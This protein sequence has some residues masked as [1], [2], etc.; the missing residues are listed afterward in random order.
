MAECPS[1]GERVKFRARH[2]DEQVICNVY[3]NGVWNR[4]E[5]YHAECYQK[6]GEPHGPAEKVKPSPKSKRS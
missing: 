3:E 5:Q 1:C 4:V 2:R 6:E